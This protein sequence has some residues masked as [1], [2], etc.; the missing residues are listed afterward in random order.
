VT[1]LAARALTNRQVAAE[2]GISERTAEAH[3][4]RLLVSL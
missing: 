4:A 1:A 3:V 2:L